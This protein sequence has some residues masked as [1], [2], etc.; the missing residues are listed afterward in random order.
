MPDDIC[1]LHITPPPPHRLSLSSLIQLL[2]LVLVSRGEAPLADGVVGGESLFG[3]GVVGGD[4][5]GQ[6]AG[7]GD[8]SA[9]GG[10]ATVSA[11]VRTHWGWKKGGG[12]G[13]SKEDKRKEKRGRGKEMKG[14]KDETGEMERKETS[15]AECLYCII[16]F[17]PPAPLRPEGHCMT[18]N[19][20]T[21][22]A[23]DLCF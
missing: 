10:L 8:H 3:D 22:Q 12:G 2:T 20:H 6:D 19:K 14:M 4:G 15:A 13:R 18:E 17:I 16:H 23:G 21:Q 9:W 5:H 1:T 11:N 7:V